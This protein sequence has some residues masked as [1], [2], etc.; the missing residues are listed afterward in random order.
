MPDGYV[1]AS[2]GLAHVDLIIHR[3]SNKRYPA[4]V[5]LGLD[6][7]YRAT[8]GAVLYSKKIQSIGRGEV[9]VTEGSCEVKGSIQ[10]PKRP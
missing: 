10:S 8:D 6:F 4:T 9:D 3:K 1:N 2:L 7:A 5:T